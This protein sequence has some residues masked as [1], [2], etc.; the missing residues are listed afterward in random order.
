MLSASRLGAPE[1][2]VDDVGGAVQALGRAEHLTAEAVGDHHVVADGD[3]EHLPVLLV[4]DRVAERRQ[5]SRR[6]PRH[7]VGHLGEG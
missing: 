4:G 3:A 6:E 5:R 7:H 2:G 1:G